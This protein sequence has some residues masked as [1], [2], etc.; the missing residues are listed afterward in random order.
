MEHEEDIFLWPN[1]DW[2]YRHEFNA[3]LTDHTDDYEVIPIDSE[4]WFEIVE[5]IFDDDHFYLG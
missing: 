1:D 4:K 2:C 3:G 5:D